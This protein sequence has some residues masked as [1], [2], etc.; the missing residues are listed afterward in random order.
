[1]ETILLV[2]CGRMGGAMRAGWLEAGRSVAVVEP[3]PHAPSGAVAT[4][5]ALPG[6]LRPAAVV[7]AVKPQEADAVLPDYARFAGSAV[8]LSIMAGRTISRMR[9]LLGDGAA[10]VRAMPNTPAAVRQGIAVACPGPGVTGAQRALC[11]GLLDAIGAVAWV[12]EEA[13]MD[14]VTAVSG[15]GP[16]YV[17]LLAEAMEAAGIAQGLPAALA[18]RL[19]R[20]TV[21]G[22]G[23]LLAASAEDAAQLR[24]N[25]TSPG[26][27]TAAA[28]AVLMAEGGVPELMR[29]AVA[30]ATRRS[31]ELAG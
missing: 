18:R 21:A 17:F 28:L 14:P 16:A 12:E 5:D 3:G 4:P 20:Q 8:F 7:L 27:T 30:E 2:G 6:G 29:R 1:M 31:R 23:A 9:A 26:G 11:T 22:S 10:V 13:L 15:S 24:R 25:V 19:A